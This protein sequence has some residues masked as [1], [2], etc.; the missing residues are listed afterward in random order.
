MSKDRLLHQKEKAAR[1]IE[2]MHAAIQAGKYK[3]A[4]YHYKAANVA[5]DQ[6]V[7]ISKMTDAKG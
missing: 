5:L 1:Q 2:L 4:M 6:M 3:T 7:A